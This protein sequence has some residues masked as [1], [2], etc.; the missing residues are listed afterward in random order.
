MVATT[1]GNARVA[2]QYGVLGGCYR[3]RPDQRVR[4]FLALAAGVLH[5]SV[6]G[7]T[8]PPK[9]GHFVG[10]W[11]FL[12]DGSLGADLPLGGRYHLSLAA[13]VHVAEPYVAIHFLDEV[14]GTSGRPNLLLTLAFGAWL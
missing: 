10:Q 6:D 5:T 12:L 2:Q 11:S 4:P 9:Q 3:F 1:T 13:H 14:V 8:D 7:Q